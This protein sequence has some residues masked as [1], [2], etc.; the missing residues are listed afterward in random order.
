MATIQYGDG[1]AYDTLRYPHSQ[2]AEEGPM[3]AP[4]QV[5]SR[6]M[7]ELA[8]EDPMTVPFRA[9]SRVIHVAPSATPHLWVSW[10]NVNAPSLSGTGAPEAY[11]QLHAP[12]SLW[13][14]DALVALGEVDD[15]IAEENLPEINDAIKTEA[16]RIV[17]ALARHPWAPT[18]Y[19]TQDAE[20]AIHFKSRD[21][22]NSV[23]ILL[24]NGGQ[25]ECYAYTS[26]KSRRAHYDVS[27][28]LP[29]GFVME[30][31]RA[32]T[33]RQ[34]ATWAASGAID[35]FAMIYYPGLPTMW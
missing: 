28:D 13:L 34:R 33:R 17:T 3:T 20:I 4:F 27:S 12:A 11:R 22:P 15:E 30:Q 1:S 26:G 6:T 7:H 18:V 8:P 29:D 16:R 14:A 25:A 5:K 9:K 21:L 2:I 23:V 24:N 31:L 35:P 10:A 32:L 19:P